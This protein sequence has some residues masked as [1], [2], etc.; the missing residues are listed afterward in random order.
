[1]GLDL[2]IEARIREKKTRRLISADPITCEEYSYDEEDKGFFEVCSWCSWLFRDIRT[3]L[4][5]ISNRYAGTAY[6]DSDF[7]IPVPQS[8]LREMYS[9]LV[10]HSDLHD[11][12]YIKTDF[13]NDSWHERDCYEKMNLLNAQKLHDILWMLNSIRYDNDLY[14]GKSICQKCIPNEKDMRCLEENPQHFEWEFRIF[15]SY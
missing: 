1:M 11:Y 6:T 9:C 15:N 2:Y 3:E 12:S 10:K 5:E 7:I 14:M 13:D 4:I 8:A